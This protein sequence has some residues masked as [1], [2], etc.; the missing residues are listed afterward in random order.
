MSRAHGKW[1]VAVAMSLVANVA[2]A[3][4]LPVNDGGNPQAVPSAAPLLRF[5]PEQLISAPDGVVEDQEVWLAKVQGLIAGAPVWLQQNV[6]SSQ[7]AQEFTANLAL[8]EQMQEGARKRGALGLKNQSKGGNVE[9][10]SLG[11][12]FNLVYTT[13]TPCRIMDSRNALGGSGV[14]GPL[15]GNHLYA[16]PGFISAG[17]N[18][19]LYGGNATSDCGLNTTVGFANIRGVALVITILNPNFDAFLG[20]S[21]SNVLATVLS[22]VALN[23]THGQGLSTQYI[24]AEGGLPQDIYFAMPAALSAN[25]IFDV[26]GYFALSQATAL[27]C[28]YPNLADTGTIIDGAFSNIPIPNCAPG[29]TKTGAG[30]YMDFIYGDTA[31]EEQSISTYSRCIW[32][33]HS[34][35]GIP[36]SNFHAETACCRIPGR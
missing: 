7:T 16:I 28:T 5:Y 8:L 24:V 33:N 11:D 10:K 27:D 26:V 34:G 36:G 13:L 23:Y 9:T 22:T 17:G 15:V 25:I 31:I 20:V 18:W 21:N 2:L 4:S 19:G 3:A 35:S 30:C 14:Q 1:V 6:L 12:G 32:N 29:Y